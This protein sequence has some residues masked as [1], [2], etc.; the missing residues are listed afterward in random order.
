M[1]KTNAELRRVETAYVQFYLKSEVDPVASAAAGCNVFHDVEWCSIEPMGRGGSL[2]VEKQV[3]DTIKERFPQQ[4]AAFK[5]NREASVDGT[6]LRNWR[7][8]TPAQVDMLRSL[9]VFS[10]EQ[11][12]EAN[13][14]VLSRMGFG[15]RDL[16]KKAAEWVAMAGSESSKIVK[17]NETLRVENEA[18]K[19][20]ISKLESAIEQLKK[21][22][23]HA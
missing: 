23:D 20:R 4:Y 17:E 1:E 7:M 9:K 16:K 3:D 14:A 10:V 15:A 19:A 22:K 6:D 18:L 11:L 12:A 2:I 21:E 5:E 8:I 13:E